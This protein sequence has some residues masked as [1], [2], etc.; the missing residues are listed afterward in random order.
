MVSIKSALRKAKSFVGAHKTAVGVGLAGLGVGAA[1]LAARKLFKG[2]KHHR[3]SV[4]RLKNQVM[5][6]SLKI[7]KQQLQRKLFREETRL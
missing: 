7:K 6:L 4:T 3:S 2:S 5:R 1:G